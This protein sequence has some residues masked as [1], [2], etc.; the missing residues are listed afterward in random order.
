MPNDQKSML[1]TNLQIHVNKDLLQVLLVTC[2]I[3]L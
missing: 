1:Q 2:Q 3:I